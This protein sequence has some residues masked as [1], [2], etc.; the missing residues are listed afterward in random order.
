M[1][2]YLI[3]FLIFIIGFLSGFIFH[4]IQCNYY[5]LDYKHK[6]ETNN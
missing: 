1:R 5:K 3:Y 4:I 2:E 6:E